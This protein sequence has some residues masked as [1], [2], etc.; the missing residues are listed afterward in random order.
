MGLSSHEKRAYFRTI[1]QKY[2][3]SKVEPSEEVVRIS[4]GSSRLKLEEAN[5]ELEDNSQ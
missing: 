1:S 5:A 3:K 2:A 4:D